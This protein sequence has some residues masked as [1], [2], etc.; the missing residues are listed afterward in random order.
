MFALWDSV[1]SHLLCFHF[2]LQVPNVL[3][4]CSFSFLCIVELPLSFNI[5]TFFS[6]SCH[7]C[8]MRQWC[9]NQPVNSSKM[10]SEIHWYVH[11]S[12]SAF[13]RVIFK[14][15]FI[16]PGSCWDYKHFLLLLFL[17][18]VVMSLTCFWCYIF[19]LGLFK[20]L[21]KVI[22]SHASVLLILNYNLDGFYFYTAN[23]NLSVI[24]VRLP[25]KTPHILHTV[26]ETPAISSPL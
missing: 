9:T 24:A 8:Q 2:S 25:G 7:R 3:Q 22:T 15:F 5:S 13:L 11:G 12:V 23:G 21:K 6:V 20:T 17:G 14:F 16:I 18:S 1:G 26:E 19:F 10:L 4:S